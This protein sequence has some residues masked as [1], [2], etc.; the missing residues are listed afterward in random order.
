MRNQPERRDQPAIQRLDDEVA[1][2]IAADE[3][4][5]ATAMGVFEA[6]EARYYAAAASMD[7]PQPLIVS[8]TT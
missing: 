1:A 3:A 6:A 2:I 8:S 4:G 5:V 7:L